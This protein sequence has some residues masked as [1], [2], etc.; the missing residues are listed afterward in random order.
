MLCRD[1][2]RVCPP[3]TL[4]GH[5]VP[6]LVALAALTSGPSCRA[7]PTEPP[8]DG[9]SDAA[10]DG[11][12]ADHAA[13]S[14]SASASA[15]APAWREGAS[16]LAEVRARGE[17]ALVYV[18]SAWC[19]PCRALEANV[20]GTPALTRA[21]RGL[22]LVKLA[23]DAEGTQALLDEL[24]AR[25]YPTLLVL[26]SDGEE[27]FRA[28]Q[29]VSLDEL[30]PALAAAA[31]GRASGL[32]AARARLERGAATSSDCALFAA[33][34]WSSPTLGERA[35]STLD[36]ALE[37]CLDEPTRRARLA[38]AR[39]GLAALAATSAGAGARGDEA[40]RARA[41]ALL[42]AMLASDDTCYAARTWLSTYARPVCRWLTAGDGPERA[43]LRE[44][45]LRGVRAVRER[46]GVPLD[47]WLSTHQA[48]LDLHRCSHET[49]PLPGDLR[50]TLV[51]AAE[52]ASAEAKT[53][54]SRHA[55]L[56]TSAYFLREAGEKA[57]ARALLEG[58]LAASDDPSHHLVT[59]SEWALADGD[60]AAAL[61]LASRA[62]AAARGRP[63][64]LQWMVHELGLLARDP[65]SSARFFERADAT[66]ELL[67]AGDDAFAG[68]NH[69][70][71]R[72]LARLVGEVASD[73]RARALVQKHSPRCDRLAEPGRAACARHFDDCGRAPA[74]HVAR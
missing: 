29:A 34:D 11:A 53:P 22:A 66:Y 59:L 2:R 33:L 44:R 46:A 65:S 5:L 30:S 48:E 18:S 74:R 47:V 49:G 4:D 12:Q 72:E 31:A 15:E 50:A 39:L 55:T 27:L 16:A 68:R 56:G 25:T 62:V 63:S 13:A 19:P 70:R 40:A 52:R 17:P 73:P 60:R 64:R 42:D 9:A 32:G 54:A 57:R 21:A 35:T 36:L 23:G 41:P 71:A 7:T 58:A 51:S 37:R 1:M 20:L 67:F 10:D 6:A 38:G 14:A 69:V 8:R 26:A 24:G 28:H 45:W 3:R 61:S 43:T